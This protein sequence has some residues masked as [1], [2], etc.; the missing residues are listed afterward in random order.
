MNCV[1]LRS[2]ARPLR[3]LS[4]LPST[5][6]MSTLRHSPTCERWPSPR[7]Q[8][9]ACFLGGFRFDEPFLDAGDVHRRM[10][11]LELGFGLS[12]AIPMTI[13][14]MHADNR[15][16]DH[17]HG[18]V[19]G[20]SQSV[21]DLGPD[22]DARPPPANDA[23]VAGGV[24]AEAAGQIAPRCSRSQDPEDAIEDTTVVHA[25]QATRLVEQHR[26]DGSPLIIGEFVAHHSSPSV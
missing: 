12:A 24:G 22:A 9:R 4:Q 15:R 26:L 19:M 1:L 6:S 21:H 18:G 23:I 11:C 7:R 25:A 13:M 5:R 20:A 8:Q 16:V 10:K 3:R 2:V 17:L 14:L